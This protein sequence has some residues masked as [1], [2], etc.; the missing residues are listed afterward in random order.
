MP[1]ATSYGTA[2][3]KTAAATVVVTTTALIPA[4]TLLVLGV[5]SDNVA[6]ATP[7]ISS[8]TAVGGGT[9]TDRAGATTQSGATAT[10]GTGV[11]V[12]CQTLYTASS[13]ASGTAITVTFNASPAA[14]AV[15][16]W[17]FDQMGQHVLR[18]TVVSAVST[19][20]SPSAATTGTA[21]A[22]GDLVIGVVGSENNANPTGDTDT[23]NGS[24][25][26]VDGIATT[27]GA[28]NTNTSIAMQ[29][30]VV[31]A[32]GA[33]TFN[34][35]GGVADTVAIV[36]AMAPMPARPRNIYVSNAALQPSF[37]R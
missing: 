19:T 37:T 16:V 28:A 5:C 1:T 3:N 7:T 13:V 23:L 34:P 35:T 31:T 8:I 6:A 36:F 22:S 2:Q 24:W 12:Y 20:G 25:S 17:G 15:A 32:T 33:Q 10:A 18:S 9:W 11:F 30:K 21:L 26:A 4:G 14:K 29:Y 27:G